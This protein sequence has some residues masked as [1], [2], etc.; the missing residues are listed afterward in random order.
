MRKSMFHKPAQ[1]LLSKSLKNKQT[2]ETTPLFPYTKYFPL[3]KGLL[4]NKSYP[5][6]ME[7]PGTRTLTTV[8]L[9]VRSYFWACADISVLSLLQP[10][11][12]PARVARTV[13]A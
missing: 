8:S 3:K 6:A 12:Q 9:N 13:D 5:T 7:G 4:S 11:E 1:I 2:K 10:E